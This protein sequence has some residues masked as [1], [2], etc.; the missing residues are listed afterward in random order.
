MFDFA[1][2]TFLKKALRELLFL[3]APRSI[4]AISCW[5]KQKFG[6]L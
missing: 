6:Q 3:K 2:R 1:I 5:I 4:G